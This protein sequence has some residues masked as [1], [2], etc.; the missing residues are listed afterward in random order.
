MT[1]SPRL[2]K[3]RNRVKLPKVAES[4]SQY[5]SDRLNSSAGVTPSG[6]LS[7]FLNPEWQSEQG[8]AGRARDTL[9]G[10]ALNAGKAIVTNATNLEPPTRQGVSQAFKEGMQQTDPQMTDTITGAL[11]IGKQAATAA[12]TLTDNNYNNN[13]TM[14]VEAY[15]GGN[16]SK[17]GNGNG[18]SGGGVKG[19]PPDQQPMSS[20]QSTASFGSLPDGPCRLPSSRMD[21]T[22]WSNVFQ[23]QVADINKN[24]SRT[25]LSVIDIDDAALFDHGG[26]VLMSINM[27]SIYQEK[28]SQIMATTGGNISVRDSF[29]YDKF[30][31]YH[32][33][34]WSALL[35]LCEI[36]SYRTW[37]PS[38]AETNTVL[39]S[40]KN[41]ACADIDLGKACIRLEEAIANYAI[42]NDLI[43]LGV[44]Y[45]QTYKKSP[46]S[47]GVHWK[48]VSHH[49]MSD[50]K[51]QSNTNPFGNT[52]IAM[53]SLSNVMTSTLGSA[54]TWS[55]DAGVITSFLLQKCKGYI[56]CRV[57]KTGAGYPVYNAYM[58]AIN[59]N[60]R[61]AFGTTTNSYVS[62]SP[63]LDDFLEI[64][65][66]MDKDNVPLYVTSQLLLNYGGSS[67][68][69]KIGYP[70]HSLKP[71]G[72]VTNYICLN[73]TT[74]HFEVDFEEVG[75]DPYQILDMNYHI[76][77]QFN[78]TRFK[79]SG[80]N[81]Q[82]FQPTFDVVNNAT[83]EYMYQIFDMPTSG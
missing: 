3:P 80:M 53:N 16:G 15:K 41:A 42:P 34:A 36:Y 4:P 44:S 56:S 40:L 81:T 65:Y 72:N 57:G 35:M 27:S 37:N 76:N 30:W 63:S 59:D 75:S 33:Y 32:R 20:P 60:V 83:R 18:N 21:S 39:R 11:E 1:R 38:F 12:K 55:H 24:T 64:A 5:Y 14:K 17:G 67:I 54:P 73:N 2:G 48:R 47:G 77:P 29:T 6:Q 46:I 52:L 28:L 7:I 79:P 66:P 68:T 19:G 58:N 71:V 61:Y 51:A 31:N 8:L 22:Y 13:Q 74:L 9:L 78:G 25:A 26:N 23:D 49:L 45:F 50:F 82:L 43:D 69:G 10:G 70:F 62:V